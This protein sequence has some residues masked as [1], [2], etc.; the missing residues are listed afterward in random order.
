MLHTFKRS[1]YYNVLFL[2]EL[3]SVNSRLNDI[4]IAEFFDHIFSF[5][6]VFQ[7]QVWHVKDT[8]QLGGDQIYAGFSTTVAAWPLLQEF[9]LP[10]FENGTEGLD[11]NFPIEALCK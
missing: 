3:H 5:L 7:D 11:N 6:V 2:Q 1:D 4:S 8:D 10:F 9:E